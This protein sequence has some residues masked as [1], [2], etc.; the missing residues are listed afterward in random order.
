MDIRLVEESGLDH[1][2]HHRESV[3]YIIIIQPEQGCRFETTKRR[4]KDAQIRPISIYL[5]FIH[6]FIPIF[7]CPIFLTFSHSSQFQGC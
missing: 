6:I 5:N 1:H 2:N 3:P 4:K 7:F